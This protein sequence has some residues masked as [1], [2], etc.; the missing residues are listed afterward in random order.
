MKIAMASALSL[1]VLGGAVLMGRAGRDTTP[2][3]AARA[4]AVKLFQSLD[5]EQK[6]LAVRE[7]KD[8]ERHV[9]QFPEV[10]RPGLPFAKLT[11]EQ[12]AM[13]ADVV[14]AMTSAY[15]AER[16]L[17]VAKQTSEN[18]R[19]VNFFG[20]PAADQP[21]AWRLAGHHL[22]LVYVEFGKEKADEIGPILLGGNP[23]KTLWD[24]EEKAAIA[25][26]AALS[27][28]EA[29]QA[30]AK[31]ANA[32]S[33]SPIGKAGVRIGDLGEKPAALAQKLLAKRSTCCRR[34]GAS[35]WRR[36]SPRPAA[37]KTCAS[38]SGAKSPGRI[39]T[40]ATTTGASAATRSCAIGRPSARTI[41]T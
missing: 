35:R 31:G 37:S 15:G 21:F 40:A 18:G 26:Y 41:F 22:T 12:K 3:E 9:E 33:G 8:K 20:E 6:K 24:D 25:F 11:A 27:P 7:F 14:K 32:G 30:Q 13:V 36:S 23:V 17:E 19:Y 39:S 10:K 28:D 2:D 5:A 34:I 29:K 1:C 16:C 4:A 38:P